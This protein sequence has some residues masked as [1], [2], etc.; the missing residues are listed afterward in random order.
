MHSKFFVASRSAALTF[1][2]ICLELMARYRLGIDAL[3]CHH[4]APGKCPVLPQQWTGRSQLAAATWCTP[5]CL[6]TISPEASGGWSLAVDCRVN[7]WRLRTSRATFVFSDLA[8][9]RQHQRCG[10]AN[11]SSCHML[12]CLTP[13]KDL[14]WMFAAKIWREPSTSRPTYLIGVSSQAS[15]VAHS[16][17]S[18]RV[19]ALVSDEFRWCSKG[20]WWNS[21]S[22]LLGD[23]SISSWISLVWFCLNT[24]YPKIQGFI[25]LIP[26]NCHHRFNT[27]FSIMVLITFPEGFP[28]MFPT[29]TTTWPPIN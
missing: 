2:S 11:L 27:S 13:R 24:S 19:W 3:P 8:L 16:C 29:K 5:S 20:F 26:M 23:S 12:D 15:E 9:V 14:P 28:I 7:P 4:G 10:L 17:D 22:L 21:S 1:G 18:T 25:I 6:P